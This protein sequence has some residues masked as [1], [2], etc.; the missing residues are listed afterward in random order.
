MSLEVGKNSPVNEI[1]YSHFIFERKNTPHSIFYHNYYS[2][3]QTRQK[4][5]NLKKLR[6]STLFIAVLRCTLPFY[7]NFCVCLYSCLNISLQLFFVN[8][9]H[10]SSNKNLLQFYSIPANLFYL[11]YFRNF[12]EI[13]VQGKYLVQLI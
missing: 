11:E 10:S 7:S 6:H 3:F 5:K 13:A 9:L 4:L 12:R 2:F 8:V 1:T